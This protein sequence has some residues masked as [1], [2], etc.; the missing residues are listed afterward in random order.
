MS[1]FSVV[2]FVFGACSC[3]LYMCV[4]GC[5][6]L[7]LALFFPLLRNTTVF[8]NLLHYEILWVI[9]PF[10]SSQTSLHLVQKIDSSSCDPVSFFFLNFLF[11]FVV[12]FPPLCPSAFHFLFISF[13]HPLVPFL[14][15]TVGECCSGRQTDTGRVLWTTFPL[16]S[17]SSSLLLLLLLS[18]IASLPFVTVTSQ[19]CMKEH[20]LCCISRQECP[21]ILDCM[22]CL[23]MT[24]ILMRLYISACGM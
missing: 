8:F 19:K 17:L 7:H 12:V 21:V 14:R 16:T 18:C 10:F 11:G 1:S 13:F 4:C 2:G 24:E 23:P 20:C 3:I 6:C 22:Y 9:W 5:G 15:C